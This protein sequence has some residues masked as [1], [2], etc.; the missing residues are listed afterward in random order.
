MDDRQDKI[1]AAVVVLAGGHVLRGRVDARDVVERARVAMGSVFIAV[2]VTERHPLVALVDVLTE[3]TAEWVCLVDAA[4]PLPDEELLRALWDARDGAQAVVD[5]TGESLPGLYHR[6]CLLQ[7]RMLLETGRQRLAGLLVAVRTAKL[8]SDGASAGL[9][10]PPDDAGAR[11]AAAGHGAERVAD[12]V[13][14]VPRVQESGDAA[15]KMPSERAVTVMLNDVEI[16]T[17]QATPAD[18]EEMAAGFLVSEGLITRRDGLRSVSVDSSRDVVYV[19]SAESVPADFK[20]RER[21]V[22][23]G[24]GKG[25]T[26]A[27]VGHAAGIA[28][29]DSSVQVSSAALYDM[30]GQMARAAVRYRDSGGM[31]SCALGRD[32]V[33]SLVR[34]DVGRHNAIDKLLGRAWLDGVSTQ[35]AVLLTSGRISYEMVVKAAKARVPVVASRTAVTDLAAGIAERVGITLVGYARGGKMIVYTHPE[36]VCVDKEEQ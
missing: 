29:L 5:S 27:S 25:V 1:P 20:Y 4:A 32:G 3:P 2:T 28:K 22:T 9:K 18:L 19:E 14:V 26:F 31:H 6:S 23:S 24:C 30:M 13:P 36:R 33:V 34:E 35:D 16:A 11:A 8:A 21:Y 12:A 17:M 15:R 10:V 7:A